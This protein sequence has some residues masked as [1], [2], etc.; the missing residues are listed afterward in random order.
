MRLINIYICSLRLQVFVTLLIQGLRG[1]G[2]P[3][4]DFID[5]SLTGTE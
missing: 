4:V 5:K 3:Q 2:N 1:D